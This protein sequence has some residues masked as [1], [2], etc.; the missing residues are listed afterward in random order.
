MSNRY[1]IAGTY[2]EAKDYAA[3]QRWIDWKFVKTID[4]IA[5]LQGNDEVH[6]VG[7]FLALPIW[8]TAKALL[9]QQANVPSMA[10]ID[11]ALPSITPPVI[12]APST[13]PI[14][15]PQAA[16]LAAYIDAVKRKVS[17][18]DAQALAIA[19]YNTAQGN[20]LV[21]KPIQTSTFKVVLK[22]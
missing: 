10:K 20:K 21:S 4:I 16:A 12:T 18:V 9:I 1:V 2:E 11:A 22:T 19:A 7:T 3:T 13:Q 8:E 14:I 15:S 17:P 6:V 5:N